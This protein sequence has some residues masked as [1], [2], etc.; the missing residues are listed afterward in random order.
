[1]LSGGSSREHECVGRRCRD[2]G[3][4]PGSQDGKPTARAAPVLAQYMAGSRALRADPPG[5]GRSRKEDA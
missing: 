2:A 5:K 4:T 3:R 1:M